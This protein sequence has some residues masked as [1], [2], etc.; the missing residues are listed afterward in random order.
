MDASRSSRCL[1]YTLHFQDEEVWF[2]IPLLIGDHHLAVHGHREREQ[3]LHLI[4]NR[5]LRRLL[6]YVQPNT[7]FL[8]LFADLAHRAHVMSL[9]FARDANEC[10][11][12]DLAS[13]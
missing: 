9:R 5:L 7:A 6:A 11:F 12:I 10:S 8:R 2:E 4:S 1:C 13:P 3:G